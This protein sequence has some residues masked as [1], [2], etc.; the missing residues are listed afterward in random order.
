[1]KSSGSNGE[2]TPTKTFTSAGATF[3]ADGVTFGD[4][5]VITSGESAGEY[6]ISDVPSETTLTVYAT[7]W[8]EASLTSVTYEVYHAATYVYLGLPSGAGTSLHLGTGSTGYV[9]GGSRIFTPVVGTDNRTWWYARLRSDAA[10]SGS[11]SVFSQ[12]DT[13]FLIHGLK[14]YA[15]SDACLTLD[16]GNSLD[17]QDLTLDF[18]LAQSGLVID[19]KEDLQLSRVKL[20]NAEQDAL[21]GDNVRRVIL[22]EV[23]IEEVG[24][25]PRF[26][27]RANHGSLN[28][29]DSNGINLTAESADR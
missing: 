20:V 15:F 19:D 25:D 4:Y 8:P 1:M 9:S 28:S 26:D 22:A 24:F 16:N 13:D 5:L 11:V 3:Q 10:L 12:Y 23:E 14:S 29:V 2:T 17:I 6:F 27:W 21:V 18:G 7:E